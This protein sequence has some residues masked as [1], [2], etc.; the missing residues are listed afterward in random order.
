MQVLLNKYKSKSAEKQLVQSLEL[1]IIEQVLQPG[2]HSL[3]L[4]LNKYYKY[5]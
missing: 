1:F 5:T 4:P 3:Q 2:Q